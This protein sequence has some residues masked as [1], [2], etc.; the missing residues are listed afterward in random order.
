MPCLIDLGIFSRCSKITALRLLKLNGLEKRL[1]VTGTEPVVVMSLNN[2]D[3]ERRPVLKRLGKQLKQVS[4]F[5]VVDQDIKFLDM[6]KVFLNLG[7]VFLQARGE[8]VVV[9]RRDGQELAAA[10]L[11]ALDG[12]QHVLGPKGDVLDTG[13][14]VVFDIFLNLRL[15]LA[16]CRLV[17]RHL[18][19]LVEVAKND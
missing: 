16:R 1:K 5:V 17:N 6:L 11:H 2:L 14:S 10:G 8:V 18:H 4:I 12:V 13:S 3:E 15:P 7:A 9:R 19:L